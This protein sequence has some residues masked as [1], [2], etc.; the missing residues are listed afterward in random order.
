MEIEKEDSFGISRDLEVRKEGVT[1]V[2]DR[3]EGL[4]SWNRW[5]GVAVALVQCLMS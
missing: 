2:E 5:S 1:I 3:E 4:R